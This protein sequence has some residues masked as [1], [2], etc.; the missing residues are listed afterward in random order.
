MPNF[1]GSRLGFWYLNA[2]TQGI[3]GRSNSSTSIL[4]VKD[5][6]YK[7]ERYIN[8]Y[9]YTNYLLDM[10]GRDLL[11]IITTEISSQTD[12]IKLKTTQITSYG[13]VNLQQ[14]SSSLTSINTYSQVWDISMFTPLNATA[15][16]IYKTYVQNGG[17]LYLLGENNRSYYTERNAS[18]TSFIQSDLGGGTV[19]FDN[20]V[21]PITRSVTLQSEFRISQPI[22]IYGPDLESAATGSLSSYGNGTLFIKINGINGAGAVMWKTGSLSNA[23]TGTVLANFDAN[24]LYKTASSID[25]LNRGYSP[26]II[27]NSLLSLNS[28]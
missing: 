7:D 22:G 16:S 10:K 4:I 20:S 25:T 15:K 28:K 21:Q 24:Y 14:I 27:R 6:G 3:G 12:Q 9:Y 19:T 23:T 2:G 8:G 17:A 13:Y 11:P 18:I 26:Y 5:Y 1:G